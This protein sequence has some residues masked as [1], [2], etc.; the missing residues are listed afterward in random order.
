MSTRLQ[1][2][3]VVVT[4]REPY[5]I[6]RVDDAPE[7]SLQMNGEIVDVLATERAEIGRAD[8]RATE[9][10]IETDEL[11]CAW[12]L[13]LAV[14]SDPDRRSP[15]LLVGAND[16][17]VWIDGPIARER[18]WPIESLADEGQTIRAI[19]DTREGRD[20]RIDLDYVEDGELWW[21]RRYV[22]GWGE[23]DAKVIVISAQARAADEDVVC[24]AID[25]IEATITRRE[26]PS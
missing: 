1:G 5:R 2:F 12:P 3:G 17:M 9:W 25:R 23:G 26:R 21:Q 15:F 13:G 22:L 18:A 11:T 6:E 14:V 7:T 10:T 4:P 16:A 24:A 20:A 19:A 8:R